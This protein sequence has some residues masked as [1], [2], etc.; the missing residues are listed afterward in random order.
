MNPAIAEVEELHR[1]FV[2]W[3][4]GSLPANAIGF[5]RLEEALAPGFT[6]VTPGGDERHRD[7][8]LDAIR[9]GHG[10]TALDIRIEAGQVLAEGEGLTVVGYDEVQ[11]SASGVTRRRS[12][13]VLSSA[14]GGRWRWLRVHETWV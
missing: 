3:Y 2:A 13:A 9:S 6:M 1:F 8:V 14:G 11:E 4:G 12:T 7:D 10:S 5:A